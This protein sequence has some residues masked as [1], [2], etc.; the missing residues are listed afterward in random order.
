MP[1]V[2]LECR[3][4]QPPRSPPVGQCETVLD[5]RHRGHGIAEPVL[6][7]LRA[8]DRGED[9][10]PA[11]TAGQRIPGDDCLVDAAH[12]PQ[13]VRPIDGDAFLVPWPAERLASDPSRR[14]SGVAPGGHRSPPAAAV[15]TTAPL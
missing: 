14:W 8:L 2:R 3:L 10:D 15:T 13:Q 5:G 7:Q 4:G 6:P 11:G 12:A 9:R 1:Q